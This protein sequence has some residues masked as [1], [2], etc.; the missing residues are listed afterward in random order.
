M[1]LHIFCT[2]DVLF[3][4]LFLNSANPVSRDKIFFALSSRSLRR[5]E[6]LSSAMCSAACR[7]VRSLSTSASDFVA[8][9]LRISAVSNLVRSSSLSFSLLANLAVTACMSSAAF[10]IPSMALF[11]SSVNRLTSPSSFVTSSAA[12]FLA[13]SNFCCTTLSFSAIS[14]FSFSFCSFSCALRSSS[15]CDS[16]A[17]AALSLSSCNRAA[18]FFASPNCL[19]PSFLASATCEALSFLAASRPLADCASISLQRFS[20]SD[21]TLSS[22]TAY[23]FT[24]TAESLRTDSNSW[25]VLARVLVSR[26]LSLLRSATWPS[27]A[28]FSE[29]AAISAASICSL[30]ELLS[31]ISTTA[32]LSCVCSTRTRS[33][34]L[35]HSSFHV[36]LSLRIFSRSP[37]ICSA[38]CSNAPLRAPT[39]R[40][41][42]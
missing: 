6:A 19:S 33:A 11:R 27:R 9:L 4:R 5:V 16:L 38:D 42:L 15:A 14:A 3:S 13:S 39:S 34:L 30:R 36:S 8:A 12:F 25:L 35:W 22:I 21:L 7:A 2:S 17:D 29:A 37:R 41:S 20:H 40:T 23:S 32:A 18:S 26:S 1:L 28:R 24:F 10:L 31:L